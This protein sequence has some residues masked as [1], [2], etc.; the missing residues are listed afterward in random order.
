MQQSHNKNN[1]ENN[2]LLRDQPSHYR[3]QLHIHNRCNHKPKLYCFSERKKMKGKYDLLRQISQH[4][5]GHSICKQ[6]ISLQHAWI[7]YPN[8]TTI[9]GFK[10][11]QKT[12][13]QEQM[14]QKFLSFLSS[15]SLVCS[16]K[17]GS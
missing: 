12:R 17:T 14:Y 7:M 11:L 16:L 15:L 5:L 2:I 8:C 13:V 4:Q 10:L 9:T 6:N 3:S 1:N